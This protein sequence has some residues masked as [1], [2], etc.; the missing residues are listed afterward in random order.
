MK[1][2]MGNYDYHAIR[3]RAGDRMRLDSHVHEFRIAESLTP[4]PSSPPLTR[5]ASSPPLLSY[6]RLTTPSEQGGNCVVVGV[7]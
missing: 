2:K 3:T 7:A 1:M 4:E 5:Q 6:E